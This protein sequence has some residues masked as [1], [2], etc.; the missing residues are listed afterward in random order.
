MNSKLI[1]RF[2]QILAF[3]V[4]FILIIMPLCLILLKGFVPEG[5]QTFFDHLKQLGQSYHLKILLNS[6]LLG[7]SVVILCTLIA[8]PLSY[9]MTKTTLAKHQWL[10][11]LIMI[12]FMTPPYIGS[13][14][15]M[16]TMQRNGLLEQ[17][18]PIFSHM[19]P[20]FFSFFGMVLIMS[21]HLTP[22]LYI[23][24]KNALMN[25]HQSQEE[26]A[27]I[28]GGT[29]FY[30]FKKIIAPLFI[31]GYSMGALLIFVKTI[32]EFG[33]PVT[34]GNRIGFRVL[35]SEIHHSAS[36]WPID[37]QRAALL[38][39][40]L[41][42]VSM[43]VWAF[44]QW[45]QTKTNINSSSGK[46]RKIKIHQSSKWNILCY[47]YV[48]CELIVTIVLPYASIFA[49]AF[50]KKMSQGFH[51]NNFTIQHFID[52]LS[53]NGSIALFNSFLLA[54]MSATLASLIGLWV[55]LI[56][57]RGNTLGRFIDF[58]S[59]LPNTV[60]GIIVVIGLI[61][62]WNNKYNVLPIYNTIAILAVAYTVLYIP[63]AV[64]NIKTVNQQ[65]SKNL[66]EAA[67][68]SGSKGWTLFRTIT[69][70]LLTP[71]ILS[72]WILIFCISMRELVASLML[73]PPNTDTSST[74]IY[75]QFE[76]G[77]SAQGMAMALLS[78]GLTSIIL[79]ILEI[80]QRKKKRIE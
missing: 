26:A 27:E 64:Q 36:I 76:Q 7:V 62:F 40:L 44:Q 80:Y 72:G 70:P 69:L 31:S 66:I 79:M 21:C 68:I 52:V 18:S 37:F 16:L 32:G 19:T 57:E 48:I 45:F 71:G 51:L 39:T 75:R 11:L 78:I 63:Y 49:N 22:F 65:I 58:T 50:M 9:I 59:L 8:L 33:T 3:I 77:D 56:T 10:D 5:D 25:I 20:Y 28:Y 67:E 1:N 24:L 61:L 55:V 23:I 13:M 34:M 6:I 73:R 15:W 30:R 42:A 74:F 4:L 54:T 12:P 29:F 46:G 43:S 14:G 47:V 17:I 60:P 35:T 41:L 2:N 53:G 38:S